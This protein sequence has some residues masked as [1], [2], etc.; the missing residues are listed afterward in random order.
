[1]STRQRF[2]VYGVTAAVL[3]LLVV[4]ALA[5]WRSAAADRE[6]QRKAEQLVSA[7]SVAGARMRDPADVARVLG[8]DGGPVCAAPNEALVKAAALAGSANGS[9]GPGARPGVADGRLLNGELL[10]ISIYC[11][12]ELPGFQR[13]VAGLE[14]G[15]LGG[16]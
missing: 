7:L 14:A 3:V 6:A 12:A 4:V 2:V 9:G 10:V 15:D 8:N 5:A 13:F 16:G 11:P 1:M